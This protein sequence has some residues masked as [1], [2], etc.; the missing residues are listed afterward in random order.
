MREIENLEAKLRPDWKCWLPIYGVFR[1]VR[2][3]TEIRPSFVK[4]NGAMD[5]LYISYQTIT[6]IGTVT[7]LVDKLR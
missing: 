7:Y 3:E 4:Y 2:H 1:I 5:L 6:A